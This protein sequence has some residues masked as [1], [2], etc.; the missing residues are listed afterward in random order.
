MPRRHYLTIAGFH[1]LD[2]YSLSGLDK[3]Y[4][5]I[6]SELTLGWEFASYDGSLY[7]W[8]LKRIGKAKDAVI[9]QV[10]EWVNNGRA[11][12]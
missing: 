1:V 7:P 2:G 10:V 5:K 8:Q 11:Q 12:E 9:Y 6:P 4:L 3:G